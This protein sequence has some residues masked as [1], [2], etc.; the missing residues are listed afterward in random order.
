[1]FNVSRKVE[2]CFRRQTVARKN[3]RSDTQKEKTLKR[4]GGRWKKES[5]DAFSFLGSLEH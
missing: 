3:D 1:M 4:T 5:R 2:R